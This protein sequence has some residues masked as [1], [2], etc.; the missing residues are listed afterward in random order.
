LRRE[1][2]EN[3]IYKTLRSQRIFFA[4]S[5]VKYH[6]RISLAFIDLYSMNLIFQICFT[7]FLLIAGIADQGS[8]FIPVSRQ[9]G[10]NHIDLTIN[11][12]KGSFGLVRIGIFNNEN[13]YPDR[14]AFNYSLAKDTLENGRLRLVIPISNSGDLS[15]SV[16]DDENE[17]GKMDYIFGIMPKEGFG[18]SNN[19]KVTSKKAPPFNITSFTY[20]G[21]EKKIDINM[22]YM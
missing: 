17:N 13:G 21:G 3:N 19:P 4:N 2:G 5:A 18:F 16:L 22:V 6:F 12:L 8:Q 1:R 14:P 9:Q 15:I 20:K 11:N 10:K 7:S